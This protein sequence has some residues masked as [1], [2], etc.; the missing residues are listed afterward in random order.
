MTTIAEA[1][2]E[3]SQQ[4]RAGNYPRAEWLCRQVLA[5]D[6]S[7]SE[8]ANT[9]GIIVATLGRNRGGG[10]LLSPGCPMAT[11][12]RRLSFQPWQCTVGDWPP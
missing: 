12:K 1:L 7:H 11:P 6:P 3:A 8:A 4:F 2:N 9:L 10:L 5:A